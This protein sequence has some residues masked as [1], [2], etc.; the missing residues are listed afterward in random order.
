MRNTQDPLV[1]TPQTM[2]LTFFWEQTHDPEE[3]TGCFMALPNIVET[4]GEGSEVNVR[5]SL[6]S[7]PPDAS[8]YI[9]TQ[10]SSHLYN[11]GESK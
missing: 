2:Q 10:L 3:Y 7:V 9:E 4:H 8:V 6:H 11:R 1:C 5:A